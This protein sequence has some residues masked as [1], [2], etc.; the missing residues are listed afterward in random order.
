MLKKSLVILNLK[1]HQNCNVGS[2][3]MAILLNRWILPIGG[4]ASE[5][6]GSAPAV[7]LFLQRRSSLVLLSCFPLPS[8]TVAEPC[9]LFPATADRLTVVLALRGTTRIQLN[10]YKSSFPLAKV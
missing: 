2:K 9:F 1:D 10:F 7:G 3:V 8:L 6:E 4:V 5:S